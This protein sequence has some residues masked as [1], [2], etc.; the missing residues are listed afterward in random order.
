MKE[1]T[2][3]ESPAFLLWKEFQLFLSQETST[4][5]NNTIV[6]PHIKKGEAHYNYLGPDVSHISISVNLLKRTLLQFDTFEESPELFGLFFFKGSAKGIQFEN[7]KYQQEAKTQ[8]NILNL[9]ILSDLKN[10]PTVSFVANEHIEVRIL[11]FGKSGIMKPEKDDEAFDMPYPLISNHNHSIIQ[12]QSEVLLF[13]SVF[14][15]LSQ[16]EISDNLRLLKWK[17][18]ILKIASTCIS[19]FKYNY[20]NSLKSQIHLD[21]K[22]K[23]RQIE[24]KIIDL[25]LGTLPSLD[26]LASEIGLSKTKMCSLFRILYGTS[27]NI[28]HQRR[29]FKKACE[30]LIETD[31]SIKEISQHLG[32]KNQGYFSKVFKRQIG[33][34]PSDYMANTGT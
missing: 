27:I 14:T 11:V 33:I 18:D 29:K 32:F 17:G 30:L 1:H 22:Q 4:I 7:K 34:I 6:H 5:Q 10:F 28:F 31:M 23:L 21:D 26:L 19:F 2:L 8:D 20:N 15:L 12:G 3:I 13:D 25:A 24:S 9:L 16:T